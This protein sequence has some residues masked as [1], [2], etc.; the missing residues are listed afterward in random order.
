M[1]PTLNA[2]VRVFHEPVDMRKGFEGLLALCSQAMKR[3]GLSGEVFVFI[4]RRR[5]RAKCIVFDGTGLRIIH[6][7]LEQGH[8]IAPWKLQIGEPLVLTHSELELLLHGSEVIGR[9][10]LTPPPLDTR[11]FNAHKPSL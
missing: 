1:W 2:T 3:D 5:T 11:G 10:R 7:R 8:F 4:G 9:V 6:K